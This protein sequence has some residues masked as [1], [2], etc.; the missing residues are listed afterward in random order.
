M[1]HSQRTGIAPMKHAPLFESLHVGP[2][3]PLELEVTDTLE[4]TELLVAIAAEL[5]ASL[6]LEAPP[7]PPPPRPPAPPVPSAELALVEA[8]P[9]PPVSPLEVAVADCESPLPAP[10]AA[11]VWPMDPPVVVSSSPELEL[12]PKSGSSNEL[13]QPATITIA[14]TRRTLR[15]MP[16][17]LGSRA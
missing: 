4:A 5:L 15:M 2:P 17:R 3:P 8:P 9:N 6:E 16:L 10:A 7:K 12:G 13:P 1:A 11:E 14:K